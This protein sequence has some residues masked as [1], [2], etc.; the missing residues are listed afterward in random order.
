LREE[1]MLRVV[2]NGVLKKMFGPMRDKARV[3]WR[4]L[5]TRNLMICTHHQMLFG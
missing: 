2:E 5:I 1:H 4:R 3:E